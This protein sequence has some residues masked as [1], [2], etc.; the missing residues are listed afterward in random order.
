MAGVKVYD[1]RRAESE[2]L[3]VETADKEAK[4]ADAIGDIDARMNELE[5]EKEE[6]LK[7]QTFEK[8]RKALEYTYYDKELRRAKAELD[9]MDTDRSETSKASAVASRQEEEILR[10][11]KEAERKLKAT[12]AELAR[13]GDVVERRAEQKELLAQAQPRGQAV[14]RRRAET[15][16]AIA[17]G[18]GGA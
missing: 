3:M 11:S 8:K 18:D 4:I 12:K 7:L 14:G 13:A 6:F 16:R 2:Q 5:S 1:Q 10:N 17:F 9:R 15:R